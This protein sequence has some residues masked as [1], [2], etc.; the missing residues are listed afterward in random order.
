MAA[1]NVFTSQKPVHIFIQTQNQKKKTPK[2]K[3][4]G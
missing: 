3:N 2:T 1:N 4:A